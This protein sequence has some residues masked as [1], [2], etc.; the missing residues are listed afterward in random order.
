MRRACSSFIAK[1]RS[2]EK[3]VHAS[4]LQPLAAARGGPGGRVGQGEPG[5]RAELARQPA[6]EAPSG[7]PCRGAARDRL[8][9]ARVE[10]HERAAAESWARS[11]G[12]R[13]APRAGS[14][15]RAA[16][17]GGCR[18]SGRPSG[19]PRPRSC[20]RAPVVPPTPR[21]PRPSAARSRGRR[22]CEAAGRPPPGRLLRAQR[23]RWE[24]QG[25]RPAEPEPVRARLA[26]D[27]ADRP[28]PAPRGDGRSGGEPPARQLVLVEL[29]APGGDA[30]RRP[31]AGRRGGDRGA[32]TGQGERGDGDGEAQAGH[33][34][35]PSCRRADRRSITGGPTERMTAL[36]RGRH[37]LPPMPSRTPR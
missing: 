21:R 20:G 22:P 19:R 3:R 33:G 4:Q 6:A 34:R 29:V 2:P 27:P 13:A 26:Q 37:P 15:G 36:H 7:G 9:A 17:G 28:V 11:A 25:A 5:R 10:V 16:T 35:R 23:K 12:S 24:R 18:P 31:V 14:P 8:V 30:A 32:R 1:K